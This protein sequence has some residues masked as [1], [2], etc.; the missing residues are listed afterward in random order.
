MG[1]DNQ[2]ASIV[3]FGVDI[4]TF[5]DSVN[6]PSKY[7]DTVERVSLYSIKRVERVSLYSIKR[8]KIALYP[9]LETVDLSVSEYMEIF[10]RV[11]DKNIVSY[12]GIEDSSLCDLL[13]AKLSIK[14]K[15][16]YKCFMCNKNNKLKFI[17]VSVQYMI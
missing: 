13:L 2:I 12:L 6:L 1:Y 4:S 9:S 7:C 5:T 8:V 10:N 14:D 15:P 17:G 16:N 3:A 11:L